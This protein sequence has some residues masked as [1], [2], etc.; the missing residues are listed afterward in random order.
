MKYN[1]CLRI[2]LFI[3]LLILT[4]LQGSIVDDELLRE[5]LEEEKPNEA[6]RMKES[7][8]QFSEEYVRQG[9]EES[10]KEEKIRRQQ[11]VLEEELLMEQQNERIRQ[12]RE[13][14]FQSSL[15][16]MNEDQQKAA[17]KQKKKDAKIVKKILKASNQGNHYSVLGL[18]NFALKIGPFTFFRPSPK[19]IKK[20]YRHRAMKTHPD[21][22]RDGKA[23]EAFVAVE[24]SAAVLMDDQAREL[25]DLEI[26]TARIEKQE[27]I[28]QKLS[29]IRIFVR[30]QLSWL[31][32]LFH[33]VL[34]PFA[35]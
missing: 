10:E 22:N 5:L 21:K 18:L 20:A 1:K 35:V 32:W 33:K 23:Q 7:G 9:Q 16:R 29:T 28:L 25:Y 34:G 6:E 8:Y 24:E 3:T 13:A 12:Q 4:K 17:R 26:K 14:D 27:R 31:I 19:D 30:D 15:E 11:A 2:I